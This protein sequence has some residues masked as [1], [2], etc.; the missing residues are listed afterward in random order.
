MLAGLRGIAF[1]SGGNGRRRGL[2]GPGKV[3]ISAG[4]GDRQI[5]PIL[6]EAQLDPAKIGVG[7]GQRQSLWLAAFTGGDQAFNQHAEILRSLNRK[8]GQIPGGT[9]AVHGAGRRL[10]QVGEWKG[11]GCGKAAG[12]SRF[13]IKRHGGGLAR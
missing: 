10:G 4:H 2:H 11:L 5:A 3:G 1:A 6:R 9:R 12:R 7:Q 8:A 13:E